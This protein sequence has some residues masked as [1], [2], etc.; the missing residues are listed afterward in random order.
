MKARRSEYLRVRITKAER[1]WL[2]YQRIG[3]ESVSDTSRRI[4]FAEKDG[5]ELSAAIDRAFL[6]NLKGP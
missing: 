6:N 2:R 4:L 1:A 3:S 5:K